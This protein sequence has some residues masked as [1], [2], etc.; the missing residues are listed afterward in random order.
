M[1]NVVEGATRK[2]HGLAARLKNGIQSNH[3]KLAWVGLG[4]LYKHS[5]NPTQRVIG[6]FFFHKKRINPKAEKLQH[7]LSE[8]FYQ[9]GGK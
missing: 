2:G 9:T 6:F 7:I 4:R 1:R 3:L 8:L 5:G